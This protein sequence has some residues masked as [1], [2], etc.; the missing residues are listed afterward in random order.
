MLIM[1]VNA[2]RLVR[3]CIQLIY[4]GDQWMEDIAN[5]AAADWC[6]SE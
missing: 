4:F 1:I 3:N 2:I 5:F 6:N